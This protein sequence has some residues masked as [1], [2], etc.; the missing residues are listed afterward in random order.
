MKHKAIC[1]LPLCLDFVTPWLEIL[2]KKWGDLTLHWGSVLTELSA[3]TKIG[4]FL[5]R[6]CWLSAS[7]Q[8]I[9]HSGALLC[10]AFQK[11]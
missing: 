6:L 10:S 9:L 5:I 1:V 3:G 7:G 2:D 4:T 8:R 11:C